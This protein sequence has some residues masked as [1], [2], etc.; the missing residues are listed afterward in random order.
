[1]NRRLFLISSLVILSAVSGCAKV[2]NF[3]ASAPSVN[4]VLNLHNK[5]R[6]DRGLQFLQLNDQLNRAAQKYAEQMAL[7]GDFQHGNVGRRVGDGWSMYGE[8][9][10]MGQTSNEE[11]MD[12]WMHSRGHRINIL[13]NGYKYIG[14]GIAK[15]K[16][17]TIYWVVDFGSK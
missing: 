12:D 2:K 15:S 9:I 16:N 10:A 3:N 6:L 8:N 13:D 14:I 1:M 17:G 4:I 5:E 7:T 11:V